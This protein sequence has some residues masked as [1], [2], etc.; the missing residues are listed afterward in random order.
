VIAEA[1][2]QRQST[3]PREAL[4]AALGVAGRGFSLCT[5]RPRP[6]GRAWPI[7]F[8]PGFP[9]GFDRADDAY[10]IASGVVASPFRC[11]GAMG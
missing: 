1:L 2:V 7:L 3:P 9:L 10:L 8:A 11:G 6:V 4:P 5:S